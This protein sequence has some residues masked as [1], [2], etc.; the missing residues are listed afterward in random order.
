MFSVVTIETDLDMNSLKAMFSASYTSAVKLTAEFETLMS[1]SHTTMDYFVYGGSQELKG[2]ITSGTISDA[3]QAIVN[4]NTVS[5]KPIGYRFHYLDDGNVAKIASYNE[6]ITKQLVPIRVESVSF[7]MKDNITGQEVTKAIAGSTLMPSDEKI[8]PSRATVYTK[9]YEIVSHEPIDGNVLIDSYTGRFTIPE[10]AVPGDIY[11]IRLVITQTILG[12]TYTK[13]ATYNVEVLPISVTN[14]SIDT[15]SSDGR[16]IAGATVTLTAY[17]FPLNASYKYVDW[18]I[19]GGRIT[20]DP[21][22]KNV[23]KIDALMSANNGDVITVT[24]KDKEGNITETY[25]LTVVVSNEVL[26]YLSMANYGDLFTIR[27]DVDKVKFESYAG[28]DSATPLRYSINVLF[29]T[30]P[31]EITFKDLT[32]VSLDGKD[33]VFISDSRVGSIKVTIISEGFVA[34]SGST[35]QNAISIPYLELESKGDASIRGGDGSNGTSSSR[36]GRSGMAGISTESLKIKTTG[37]GTLAITGGNGGDGLAGTNGSA[38]TTGSVGGA[39]VAGGDGGAG[40]AGISSASIE[41]TGDVIV[42][43]GNGGK[44]GNGGTGGKGGLGSSSSDTITSNSGKKGG[45]GEADL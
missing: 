11:T 38:G 3:A 6:Y 23:V 8:L 35:N 43:G 15:S 10:D 22:D 36:G 28:F 39:G 32:L 41:I 1:T 25:Q 27:S 21:E 13:T 4:A 26:V 37:G 42:R 45:D 5:P 44:G 40:G 12:V 24:A 29:R 2:M 7:A 30:T 9:K 19:A 34:L 17:V 14:I 33:L 16:I 20:V 18:F 31:L